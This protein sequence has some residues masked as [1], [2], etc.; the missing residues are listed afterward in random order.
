MEFT[1]QRATKASRAG[2]A[3]VAVALVV[4]ASLPWWGDSSWMRA[5]VE[6][7]C[8]LTLAQMWN[9]L[10][11]YGGVVSIGQQAFLGLG[12]Y[13]LFVLADH[14][15]IDPFLC[16]PLAGVIA[17]VIAVPTAWIVFRLRGGYFAVGTW[18]VAEVY[19]LLIANASFLGGGSGKS[20]AA[21]REFSK[22]VRESTT[23]WL[24]LAA[25]VATIALI[26]WLLRS[27]HGLALTSIRDSERAAASQGI[28]IGATKFWVYIVAAT[29]CGVAGA[30]Y[31]LN[32][33]R[34]SPDAAFNVGWTANIIF[35]VV[36]GGI[37]TIEGPIVGCLLFFML[38]GVLAD[39]GSTYLIVLGALAVVAMVKFPRGLWGFVQERFDLRFFPVQRRLRMEPPVAQATP[40]PVAAQAPR[41]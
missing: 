32:T 14:A 33:V 39:Y 8:L 9:L 27:R 12:G 29:G 13:A 40:S 16:V 4:L 24:A 37:G 6:F 22:T 10:A 26:Y 28:D 15:H 1:V 20:L 17:A 35:I 7:A 19:R 41:N 23:Y 21:V 25:A 11:G 18:A 31:F 30:L 38:R 5:I 3:V 2:A 36:I 34:I